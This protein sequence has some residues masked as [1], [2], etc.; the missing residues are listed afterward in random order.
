MNEK[1]AKHKIYVVQKRQS[2]VFSALKS[3]KKVSSGVETKVFWHVWTFFRLHNIW[4]SRSR[5]DS[6]HICNVSFS[7]FEVKCPLNI[8]LMHLKEDQIQA[9]EDLHFS[10]ASD[11]HPYF[12]FSLEDVTLGRRE[13]ETKIYVVNH[14]LRPRIRLRLLRSLKLINVWS[15]YKMLE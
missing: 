8:K 3:W 10:D 13:K 4:T 6:L 7:P 1:P 15:V 12:F 5:F 11:F 2:T 9:S 14:L